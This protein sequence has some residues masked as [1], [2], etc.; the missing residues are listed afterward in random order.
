MKLTNN[1]FIAECTK[2]AN[3]ITAK[4][5]FSVFFILCIIAALLMFNSCSSNNKGAGAAGDESDS[6][7]IAKIFESAE[8]KN[9]SIKP[10]Y[11]GEVKYYWDKDSTI[12]KSL[13]VYEKGELKKSTYYFDI[14]K[15][16]YEYQF[17]C[18][19]LQGEQKTY[20]EN[21]SLDNRLYYSYGYRV[22]EGVFYND[23]GIVTMRVTYSHD[24]IKKQPLFYD[25]SGNIILKNEPIT[26]NDTVKRSF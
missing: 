22:G 8:M 16:R 14:G 19:A 25:D 4:I 2:I 12:L 23:K 18:G 9:K 5:Y 21:G 3:T 1:V 15:P 13:H 11:T 6:C 10:G 24:T 17:R 20:H 26:A 7:A